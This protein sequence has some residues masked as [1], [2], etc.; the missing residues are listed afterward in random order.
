M[1]DFNAVLHPP[2]AYGASLGR[3]QL[4]AVPEDFRV[5]EW[6]GFEPD[7]EGDHWLLKV[8]KRDANTLWVAKQLAKIGNV[9]PKDVGFA[10]IKD[11]HAVTEQSFTVPAR[12]QADW[13]QVR[14][15]GFEVI[16]ATRH[17]RKLKRGALRGNDFDIVLREFS[18]DVARLAERVALISSG[19]PNY[20]GPQRFGREG[21]NLQ[22]ATQWM[23]TNKAPFDR[24]DRSF[25]LSAARAAVFN[26][27]L[28]T[29]VADGSWNRLRPGD[30][31]N[32]DG[33]GSVFAIESIDDVLTRRCNELDIHPTGPL[34][35]TGS[36]AG[37]EVAQLEA[38][39]SAHFPEFVALLGRE[40]LEAERRPLR[41][42]VDALTCSVD[43]N[44]VHLSFRLPRGSFATTV[45]NEFIENAF[46]QPVESEET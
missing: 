40:R 32:L 43:G 2:R 21:N 33:S 18:G 4:R 9:H 34:W 25:A 10:G 29:R 5:R 23:Q 35:G 16:S 39:V 11:R 45:L 3:A 12:N 19:V 26:A 1:S 37:G 6:L 15:D 22:V 41:M 46:D 31:A 7:G 44:N 20:F 8:R 13:S 14:G 17:R 42:R 24:H 28:A 38:N 27:V 36:M 30:V